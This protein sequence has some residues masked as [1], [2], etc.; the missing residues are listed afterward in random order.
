MT[1]TTNKGYTKPT[2]NGDSGVWGNELNTDL[3]TIDSNLGGN[4]S[5]NVA[6]NTDVTASASQAANLVQTLTGT[7]TG[8]INYKLPATGGFYVINNQTGGAFTVTVITVTG[9]STGVKV[10]QGYSISLWSDGTNVYPDSGASGTA[11]ERTNVLPSGDILKTGHQTVTMDGGGS[12]TLTF[13]TAFPNNIYNVVCCA[14]GQ[15]QL[16]TPFGF[17]TTS[18]TLSGPISFVIEVEYFAI[19]N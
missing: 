17:S 13:A 15:L 3:D 9:G 10:P 12:A 2:V 11:T 14:K 18:I 7:L 5:V 4:V 16:V 8:S 6:G 19:G 1:T